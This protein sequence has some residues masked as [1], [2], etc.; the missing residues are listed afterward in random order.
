MSNP[1]S[2]VS[3]RRSPDGLL[4]SETFDD[5]FDTGY[6]YDALGLSSSIT[7][8]PPS[9]PSLYDVAIQ[10]NAYGA[11]T[12]VTD[13]DGQ[14]LDQSA[15]YGYDGAGRLR[16]AT[17]GTDPTGG[18]PNQKY[19]FGY[20]YDALQNMTLRTVTGPQDIGVLAGTYHYGERG[21]GPRQLTSVTPVGGGS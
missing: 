1:S 14:G 6:Q 18:A 4:L 19:T 7:V 9:A 8:K 21:Y 10:R 12:L 17:L 20:Q 5:G 13:N 11:P 16:S 3:L 2:K 15:S